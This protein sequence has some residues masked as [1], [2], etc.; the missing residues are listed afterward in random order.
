LAFAKTDLPSAASLEHLAA[1]LPFGPLP[2]AAPPAAGSAS[3]AG[4]S[5]VAKLIGGLAVVGAVVAGA[6]WLSSERDAPQVPSV[7]PP[8]V[9]AVSPPPAESPEPTAEPPPVVQTPSAANPP[10]QPKTSGPSEAALLQQAQA[11][12]KSDPARSLSL[13]QEHRRR[14]PKGALAQEREVIAIDALS[15]LGRSGEAGKRAE[16]FGKKYPGSA[17]QKKVETSVEP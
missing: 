14:F 11:A 7:T 3:G 15:R 1:Q 6:I 4:A 13:T 5:G 16:D 12:L 10:A 2:V 8:G 9:P 17:H